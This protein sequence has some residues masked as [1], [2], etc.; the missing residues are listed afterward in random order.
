MTPCFPVSILDRLPV[1]LPTPL[2]HIFEGPFQ[3]L[4]AFSNF[5]TNAHAAIFRLILRV[6]QSE[7]RRFCLTYILRIPQNGGR[8]QTTE[9]S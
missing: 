2:D 9:I 3:R 6:T 7:K 4:P 1:S 8:T 5:G